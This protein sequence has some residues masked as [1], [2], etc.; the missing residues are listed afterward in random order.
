MGITSTNYTSIGY[1]AH[2]GNGDVPASPEFQIL[3]TTGGGPTSAL[4]TAV[5]EVIRNDRQTD[6]LVLTDAEVSGDMNYEL[7]YHPY[8]PLLISLLRDD[9]ANG[10]ADSYLTGITATE[11]GS[12]L[13]L[14]DIEDT[15]G[16]GSYINI[17]GMS[18]SSVDGIYRVTGIGTDEITVTPPIPDDG[19]GGIAHKAVFRNASEAADLYCFRKRISCISAGSPVYSNFFY[20]GCSIS[21]ASFNFETGSILNG[22]VSVF[23]TIETPLEDTEIAGTDY[24]SQS[25]TEV[26]E[27]SIMNAVTSVAG[28]SLAGLTSE[29]CFQTMNLTIDN[30]TQGAKCIGTLGAVD[31]TDFTLNVTADITMYFCDLSVYNKFINSESFSVVLALRDGDGNGLVMT[32]PKCKFESLDVPIDGKDN[33]LTL[34]GGLRALRDPTDNYMIEFQFMDGSAV[35]APLFESGAVEDATDTT[36]TVTFD[37]DVQVTDG[38][39]MVIAGVASSPTVS[40]A[41]A[42]GDILTLTMSAA[43]VDTDNPTLAYTAAGGNLLADGTGETPVANFGPETITNNVVA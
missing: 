32:M 29:S 15:Y 8:K 31:V 1:V 26:A 19:T 14:A 5:S 37:S 12:I 23:G 27:Y 13:G 35:A 4:T 20:P 11:S 16:V 38:T 28:I 42:S 39:N 2:D 40:A 24:A 9:S 18:P 17:N 34:T 3:P 22:T 21:M 25:E 7:S 30:G 36:M 10:P 33:F 41:V 43:V 6:D